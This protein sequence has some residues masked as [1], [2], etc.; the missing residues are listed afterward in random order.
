MVFP[1]LYLVTTKT[2]SSGGERS[3]GKTTVVQSSIRD[4]DKRNF[5]W[6]L[7]NTLYLIKQSEGHGL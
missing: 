2:G 6:I 3:R 4:D 1:V 7:F 5:D